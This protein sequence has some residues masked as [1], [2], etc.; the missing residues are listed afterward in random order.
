M[1]LAFL[2]V[3]ILLSSCS[4]LEEDDAPLQDGPAKPD[5]AFE[6]AVIELHEA[7]ELRAEI[8]AHYLDQYQRDALVL[9]YENVRCY[10]YDSLGRLE[11]LL[12]CDSLKYLRTRG[13][14]RAWGSV[15]VYGQ[16]LEADPSVQATAVSLD[17]LML[18]GADF[19]LKTEWVEWTKRLQRLRTEAPVTFYTALDTLYG[20]GFS[21]NQNLTNW[22]IG[23][24]SGV[25]YRQ[26][27][28]QDSEAKADSI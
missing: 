6:H 5:Q 18:H 15:E 4:K 21:S 22:E 26:E 27:S 8:H 7:G 14:L 20:T 23:S 12:T 10:A 11:S 13:D 1:K 24:P 19:H 25:S 2:L 28:T 9:L 16:D 3:L 17:S